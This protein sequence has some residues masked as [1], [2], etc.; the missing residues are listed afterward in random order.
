MKLKKKT[1]ENHHIFP[2]NYL[3]NIG[4]RDKRDYN[5]IANMVYIEYR[6]NINI[7]D[8]SP[9]EYWPE[10]L[11]SLSEIDKIDIENNY[12]ERYDLPKEFW[13]LDYNRFLGERRKLMAKSI[14]KYFEA[15]KN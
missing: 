2:R 9:Q 3:K 7:S 12:V 6:D 1:L 8:T 13:K 14:N 5:Q 15:L 11:N 4:V 10:M